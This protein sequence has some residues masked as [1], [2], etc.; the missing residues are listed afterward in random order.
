M[1]FHPTISLIKLCFL[2]QGKKVNIQNFETCDVMPNS[3]EVPGIQQ[4]LFWIS[5]CNNQTVKNRM[6]SRTQH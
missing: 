5:D 4:Y 2:G 3:T 6:L 1:L